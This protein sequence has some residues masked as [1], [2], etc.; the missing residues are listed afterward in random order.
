MSHE[1]DLQNAWE[2]LRRDA[3]RGREPQ[4]IPAQLGQRQVSFRALVERI[5]REFMEEY[6]GSPLLMEADTTTRRLKLLLP[7]VD[8][9]LSVESIQIGAEDKAA[10][11]NAAYSSLFGYGPL[12]ALFLDERVTTISLQGADRASVRY[13]HGDLE[14]IGPLFDDDLHLKRI[15]RRLL[16]DAGAD[17]Y[18]EEPFIETGLR[19]NHRPV[20]ITVAT[21]LM[22]YSYS[23]DIRVHPQTLPLLE[24]LVR[25]NFLTPLAARLLQAMALST[26]GFVIVGDTE[27]GKTTLL[28]VLA[29]WLPDPARCVAVERTGE[30]CLPE[31]IH[32]LTTQWPSA[33]APGITFG[34]QIHNALAQEPACILLDEV[35]A[36]EPES[37]ADLLREPHAPRQ[38]WSFRGPFDAKRLRN[39]LSMLARRADMSQSE[40]L[41]EALYQRL[42]FV[43]TV[44]RAGGQIRL[45]S[46]GEWQYRDSDYPDF[47]QLMDTRDGHLRLTG[48]HPIRRLELP[49]TFWDTQ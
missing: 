3:D 1:D 44:W 20:S 31:T 16:V 48:E 33:D 12:D 22:S 19:I 43:V 46:I 45:Y 27:S 2:E 32:R 28:S 37:I 30:L 18:E 38:I 34:K 42:P 15:L 6:A 36:D 29:H 23:A 35:R 7:T 49:D 8:Y 21:P 24:D 11:M 4:L 39:A 40:V 9:I 10:L 41:V 17:L 26:G 25:S 14:T 13:G 47:V 5:E